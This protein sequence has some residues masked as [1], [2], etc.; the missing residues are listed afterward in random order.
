MSL[1][2][3]EC[4]TE[5]DTRSSIYMAGLRFTF[6]EMEEHNYVHH[7]GAFGVDRQARCLFLLRAVL[8][9]VCCRVTV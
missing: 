7:M 4:N 2:V 9:L 1:N 8:N 5:R 6:Y 3:V